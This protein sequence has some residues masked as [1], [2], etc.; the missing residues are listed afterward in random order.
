M[1]S[2]QTKDTVNAVAMGRLK[3]ELPAWKAGEAKGLNVENMLA[4]EDGVLN[5]LIWQVGFHNNK[6][7]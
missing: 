7:K 1:L 3:T 5:E 4:V 6:T 2:S